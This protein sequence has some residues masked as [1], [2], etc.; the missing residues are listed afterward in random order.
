MSDGRPALARRHRSKWYPRFGTA[1]YPRSAARFDDEWDPTPFAADWYHASLACPGMSLS[2]EAF[3][4]TGNSPPHLRLPAIQKV[5]RSLRH[6]LPVCASAYPRRPPRSAHRRVFCGSP[7]GKSASSP[8]MERSITDGYELVFRWA[9]D[10][11]LDGFLEAATGAGPAFSRAAPSAVAQGMARPH[12]LTTGVFWRP[13]DPTDRP[14]TPGP[15]EK[16]P[17]R[18]HFFPRP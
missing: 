1:L 11:G 12:Q 9:K 18:T 15:C 5:R 8:T 13:R 17:D 3:V 16:R 7:H 4:R 10:Q 2:V 14:R 6:Q